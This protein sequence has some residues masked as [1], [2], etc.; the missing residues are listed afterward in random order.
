MFRRIRKPNYTHEETMVLLEQL[1][2]YK[3]I[4]FGRG[5]NHQRAEVWTIIA[6]AVNAVPHSAERTRKELKHRWKDLSHRMRILEKKYKEAQGNNSKCLAR[7]SPYYDLVMKILDEK[8]EYN[9]S[10]SPNDSLNSPLCVQRQCEETS[11]SVVAENDVKPDK[12]FLNTMLT[13]V[14]DLNNTATP[15][16]PSSPTLSDSDLRI[17]KNVSNSGGISLKISTPKRA[18][19]MQNNDLPRRPS[20]KVIKKKKKSGS[21]RPA[22]C[23]EKKSNLDP[24][25]Y[26]SYMLPE[27]KQSPL[28]LCQK[29]DKDQDDEETTI[30]KLPYSNNN[31][32]QNSLDKSLN[33][34]CSYELSDDNLVLNLSQKRFK[35]GN[36][37]DIADAT[38]C[39]SK[40]R[41]MQLNPYTQEVMEVEDM[42]PDSDSSEDDNLSCKLTI[43]DVKGGVDY[44]TEGEDINSP[45]VLKKADYNSSSKKQKLSQDETLQQTCS[46]K[47]LKKMYFIEKIQMVSQRTKCL[48]LLEAK[49]E[50]ELQLLRQ[51]VALQAP[52]KGHSSSETLLENDHTVQHFD[53]RSKVLPKPFNENNM[54][55]HV[56]KVKQQLNEPEACLA[57]QLCQNS[58][59]LSCDSNKLS[60][61]VSKASN[62]RVN[63]DKTEQS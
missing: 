49:L 46:L 22:N 59:D 18:N 51:Q 48:K 36:P 16:S 13:N 3:H 47:E 45:H 39:V 12:N 24:D 4:V 19:G 8:T 41:L 11:W 31:Y 32:N 20:E 60:K 5:S 30:L 35:N 38:S 34:E 23:L 33:D 7:P 17:T 57:H 42:D 15:V 52:E 10:V 40:A 9:D 54:Q 53:I 63:L 1:D 21:K 50:Y 62:H 26:S 58:E 29:S 25:F 27:S 37:I 14:P 6:D 2:M 56:L 43:S 61:F 44:P 55:D 28:N